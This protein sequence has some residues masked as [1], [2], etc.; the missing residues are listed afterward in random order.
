[1]TRK[2]VVASEA[3]AAGAD[4]VNDVSALGDPDMPEV[5][6]A[7]VAPVVLMHSRGELAS[8][9]KQIRFEQLLADVRSELALG[10]RRA[11]ESGIAQA[12]TILD[13]GIGF[14]KTAAQNFELLRR[15][16]ELRPLGR[17]LLVGASRKSFLG[18]L[19]GAPPTRRLA[20]SLAAGGW[21][22]LHG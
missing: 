2:A 20:G 12:R 14:G 3:L 4:L 13:P 11:A 1:D 6:A 16:D 10:L 5:L 15:L 22:A 21:A 9:Q 7:S 17:P 19:S 8:M 18:T